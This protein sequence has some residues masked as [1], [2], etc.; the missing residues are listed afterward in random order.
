ME[1]GNLIDT[2]CIIEF[3]NGRLSDKVRIYLSNVLD[4][5]PRISIINKI[6][7]LGFSN[8]GPVIPEL[9][10]MIE[11][12]G[13]TDEIA[14]ETVSIRKAYKI[15]L[16]YAI[17]AATAICNNLTLITRNAADFKTIKGLALSNPWDK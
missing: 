15:K 3:A 7:I 13:L 1:Q 14:D 17:I 6:E 11:I 8:P 16:P 2:N 12:I 9:V 4:D 10:K 5:Q